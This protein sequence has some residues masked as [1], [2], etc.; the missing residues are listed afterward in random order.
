M[1]RIEKAT[2]KNEKLTGK[3]VDLSVPPRQDEKAALFIRSGQN[4]R[5]NEKTLYNAAC[6][7]RKK[8]AMKSNTSLN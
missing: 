7:S 1:S 6:R 8:N 5:A 4:G 2:R 3:Y